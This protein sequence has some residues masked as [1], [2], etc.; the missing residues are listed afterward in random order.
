MVVVILR[1]C[2]EHYGK[3]KHRL[4]SVNVMKSRRF[5]LLPFVNCP[6]VHIQSTICLSIFLCSG[7][8]RDLCILNGGFTS[9][10]CLD[11][12]KVEG[13]KHCVIENLIRPQCH[14]KSYVKGRRDITKYRDNLILRPPSGQG[15][16][17]IK[18]N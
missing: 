15:Q 11:V 17:V 9:A 12:L 10:Q 7:V 6:P 2:S 16:I 5:L 3:Q 18:S 4:P 14:F 13:Q 1:E 8:S